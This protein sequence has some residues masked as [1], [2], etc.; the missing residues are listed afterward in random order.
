MGSI[1]VVGPGDTVASYIDPDSYIGSDSYVGPDNYVVDSENYLQ[2]Y[3]T[4]MEEIDDSTIASYVEDQQK[5]KDEINMKGEVQKDKLPSEEGQAEIDEDAWMQ[6]QQRYRPPET[7]ERQPSGRMWTTVFSDDGDL[8]ASEYDEETAPSQQQQQQAYQEQRVSTARSPIYQAKSSEVISPEPQR[9]EEYLIYSSRDQQDLL[10]QYGKHDKVESESS[11]YS[12]EKDFH[13]RSTQD[14]AFAS[15]D[16]SFEIQM[17][18]PLSPTTVSA[19]IIDQEIERAQTT[20]IGSIRPIETGTLR[21]KKKRAPEITIT[22]HEESQ[23]TGEEEDSDA[24]TPPS[25]EE[26]DYPDQVTSSLGL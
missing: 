8:A 9:A 7:W 4:E 20:R 5:P 24:E 3:E 6:P 13:R 19:A 11:A 10:E 2:R 22:S 21:P 17:E 16:G 12:Q 23:K 1:T 26:D 25:S 15:G 18:D 14:S